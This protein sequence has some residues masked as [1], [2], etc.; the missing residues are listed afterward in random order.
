MTSMR[1]W[2]FAERLREL[3]KAWD[4][5]AVKIFCRQKQ[6]FGGDLTRLIAF[7][8]SLFAIAPTGVAHPLGSAALQQIHPQCLFGGVPELEQPVF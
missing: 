6:V 7:R 3:H 8:P 5:T 1:G 2:R 4:S